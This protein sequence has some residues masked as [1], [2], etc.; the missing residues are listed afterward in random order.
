MRAPAFGATPGALYSAALD[1]VEWA[2]SHGFDDVHVTEHH[3]SEDGYCPSP[4]VLTSA[5][6]ARTRT[7]RFE[8]VVLAPL[9]DPIRLAED[10]AVLDLCSAGRIDLVLAAGYV[11][12][13]FAMFGRYTSQRPALMS[14]AVRVLKSGWSG[15]SFEYRGTK[16]RVTP[17]PCQPG[18]PRITMGGSSV[19]AARRAARLADGFLPTVPELWDAYR[20]ACKQFGRPCGPK[21]LRRG[22]TFIHVAEDPE[23][24]WAA[25]APHA[26]H[27]NNSYSQWIAE[28][29]IDVVRFGPIDGADALR[30]SGNYMVLTPNEC[31]ELVRGVERLELTPLIG[32]LSPELSWAGLE[33]FA[34]KVLPAIKR[35]DA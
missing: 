15:E 13:E 22:P 20:D 33:L 25:I 35:S 28:A 10:L 9:Y 18:G 34:S 32:G 2:D 5:L 16:V 12:R 11:E 8:P 4:I 19:G 17:L 31:I 7:M 23:R 3:G 29:G 24:A 27:E 6:V 26:V 14:E 1:Q 30:A 21:P